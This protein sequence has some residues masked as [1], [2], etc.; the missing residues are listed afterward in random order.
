MVQVLPSFSRGASI[1]N[2]ISQGVQSGIQTGMPFALKR[3]EYDLQKERQQYQRSMLQDSLE[4]TSKYLKQNPNASPLE[5]QLQI[6]KAF[7]GTEGGHKY[8]AAFPGLMQNQRSKE[9]VSK[10]PEPGGGSQTSGGQSQQGMGHQ[11]QQQQGESQDSPLQY[12]EQP[13]QKYQ[14]ELQQADNTLRQ[15]GLPPPSAQQQEGVLAPTRL[16]MG[17][18]PQ[19]Y[20]PQD[21]MEVEKRAAAQNIDAAPQIT[22]MQRRDTVARNQIGDMTQ[23]AD[24]HEKYAALDRERESKDIEEAQKMYTDLTDGAKLENYLSVQLPAEDLAKSRTQQ[25]IARKRLADINEKVLYNIRADGRKLLGSQRQEDSFLAAKNSVKPLI[26]EGQI[27]AARLALA[28]GSWGPYRQELATNDLSPQMYESVKKLPKLKL[29]GGYDVTNPIGRSSQQA[30][31]RQ[32]SHQA[33]LDKY[34]EYLKKNVKA[35]EPDAR[36]PGVIKGGTPLRVLRHEMEGNGLDYREY[37]RM[38][39][40][41]ADSGELKLDRYQLEQLK[42]MNVNPI[43]E[44]GLIEAILGLIPGYNRKE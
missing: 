21:Y 3:Q 22:A 16:G 19:T 7:A 35:G 8:A 38:L 41:M 44:V 23:A 10:I 40:Q 33:N 24:V 13:I 9:A 26:A 43:Q 2:A 1:G 17:P 4:D 28:E 37:G 32:A 25:I 34:K 12:M 36:F 27:P 11:A 20:T 31:G 30:K 29:E 42:A 5:S 14:H 15:M 6:A 39:N 18:I